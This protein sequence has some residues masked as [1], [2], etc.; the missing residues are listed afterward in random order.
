[1]KT[2]K[3]LKIK[4]RTITAE[5]LLKLRGLTVLRDENRKEHNRI[6]KAIAEVVKEEAEEGCDDY[7]GHVSD[8]M[9]DDGG[10]GVL[11]KNLD[12]K[13]IKNGYTIKNIK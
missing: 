4:Q 12:I 3:N 13:V 6:V 1:M 8:Y 5:D 7:Y 2:K 10:V 9:W 11:L